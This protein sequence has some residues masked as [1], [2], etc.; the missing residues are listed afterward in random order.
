MAINISAQA[1]SALLVAS[2]TIA[3]LFSGDGIETQNQGSMIEG[4]LTIPEYQR[5]YQWGEKEISRL[6]DDYITHRSN[7]PELPFYLGSIILHQSKGSRNKPILNIIDGQ[8]RL[9][10]L[11]MIFS[12][13]RNVFLAARDE[14]GRL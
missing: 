2:C 9:T 6:L 14:E 10:C 13:V 5:A 1:Q 4:Q 7:A 11:A 12:A 3:D 8:Q